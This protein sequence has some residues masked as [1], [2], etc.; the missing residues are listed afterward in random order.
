MVD[1]KPQRADP[2]R[3]SRQRFA[4]RQWARR[5]VAW[6]YVVAGVLVLGLLAG[7][8]Y[9]VYFSSALAIEGVQVSGASTLSDADLRRAADVPTGVPLATV[10]L[11][12]IEL[13]VRSLAVVKSADV[14]R[15]W[16]HDVRIEVTERVPVAVVDMAG[17]VRSLDADGV[18]F[19]GY[20]RAPG[21]LPRVET[22]ADADADALREAAAVVAAL[23]GAVSTIVDHVEVLTVDQITLALRDGREVRWGSAEQGAEKAKVLAVLLEKRWADVYDVSVPGNPTTS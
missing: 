23:P 16:P 17:Q 13:R 4:R 19:G 11:D 21:D 20:Q 1:Q 7:G 15:Q 22:G 9:T 8:V 6:K 18:V 5:W 14:S 3:R 12:A 2:S 10:D